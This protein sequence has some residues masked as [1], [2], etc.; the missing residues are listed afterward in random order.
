MKNEQHELD[1]ASQKKLMLHILLSAI[2]EDSLVDADMES[3]FCYE[4]WGDAAVWRQFHKDKW[5]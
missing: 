3:D 1:L 5:K 2:K 4:T